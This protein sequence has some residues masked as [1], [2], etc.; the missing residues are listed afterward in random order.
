MVEEQ[1]KDCFWRLSQP[2]KMRMTSRWWVKGSS[3]D[4]SGASLDVERLGRLIR[5][6]QLRCRGS[7]S[8]VHWTGFGS[9]LSLHCRS[10]QTGDGIRHC[11][12]LWDESCLIAT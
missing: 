3:P 10:P 8:G 1:K 12:S 4:S 7:S 5:F 11:T 9:S 2:G 6:N